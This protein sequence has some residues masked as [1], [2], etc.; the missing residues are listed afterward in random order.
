MDNGAPRSSAHGSSP[1]RASAKDALGAIA[2]AEAR[3]SERI[4][5]ALAIPDAACANAFGADTLLE[6]GDLAALTPR[7]DAALVEGRRAALV[8][9]AGA[10]AAS[11][12][13]L[14]SIARR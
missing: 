10:L 7:F 14:V 5:T 6:R 3:V 2:L 9:T 1:A 11:R 13:L 8:A 4:F 12:A